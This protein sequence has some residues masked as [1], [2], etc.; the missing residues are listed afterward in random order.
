M[1]RLFTGS[2]KATFKPISNHKKGSKREQLGQYTLKTL[3]SG[4]MRQAVALPPGE[5]LNEWI[6]ANTVDFFNGVSLIWGLVLDTEM[7]R[8]A[9]GEGFPFGYEYLWADGVNIKT[10]IKCSSTEYVE[11]VMNW[12]EEHINNEN[13]FPNGSDAVFPR[14]FMSL[15]RQIYT[16]MFRIFAIVYTQHFSRLEQLGAAAHLNTSFK[17]YLF[18]VWEFDLI[19][20]RELDAVHEIVTE[21]R[22]QYDAYG[23]K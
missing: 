17:H 6:A 5:D 23:K 2:K 14:N 16:R 19:D 22:Q 15:V 20:A 21:L 18:F 12:V 4:N 9:N 11:Y 3:G 8:F 13:V 7:P 1:F 10:P